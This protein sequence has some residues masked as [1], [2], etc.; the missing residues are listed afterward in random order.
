[1][2]EH[3]R[4]YLTH[5][6]GALRE[7]DLGWIADEIEAELAAGRMVEKDIES[8]RVK[9]GLSVEEFGDDERLAIALRITLERVQVGYAVWQETT[10]LL[11]RRLGVQSVEFV[12]VK[13][14]LAER[15]EPFAV[16]FGATV[17]DLADI[18]GKVASECALYGGDDLHRLSARPS[19]LRWED[20]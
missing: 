12:D 13:G 14:V 1:M 19:R 17:D 16:G 15:F 4:E 18:F 20:R 11:Q 7:S 2:P 5:L 3:P 6:L 10:E 8:G 9:K